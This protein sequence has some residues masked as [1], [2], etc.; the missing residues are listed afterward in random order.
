MRR[1]RTT[2]GWTWQGWIPSARIVGVAALE[3]VGKTRFFMDLARRLWHRLDWPDGQPTLPAGT[4]TVWL[5]SDGHQDEI[6]DIADDFGIPD[7]A[8]IL[9]TPKDDP[10]GNTDLDAKE[11]IDWLDRAIGTIKPGI[12][13][14]DTLTY[15]TARDLCD[16]RA[17]AILKTPLVGLVQTH[18]V[19]MMLSLH[20]SQSG[21]ALGRRIKGITRTLIHLECPDPDQS[22]HLRL[23]VEKSYDRKPA[24]LG[25]TMEVD[26]NRYDNTPPLKIDPSKGGRPSVKRDKAMQFIR[27]ELAE[28]Q[29]PDRQ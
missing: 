23:W 14:I 1:Q 4:K 6:L 24:A 17:V 13:F 21:Q 5:C 9:P 8:I 25:V 22:E 3:G 10:Y 20:L 27:D 16:Q 11:T 15:A 12:V 19:N 29:R 7:D 18:R 28:G 26:G 2:I